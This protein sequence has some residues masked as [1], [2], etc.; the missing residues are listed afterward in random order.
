MPKAVTA[1]K[2]GRSKAGV[3]KAQLVREAF[4][5]LGIDASAKDV[6]AACD[7]HGVKIAPA[8]ISNI[9]TKLKEGR[10]GR[11][12]VKTTVVGGVTAKELI[13]VRIMAEKVGGIARAKELL[14]ILHRLR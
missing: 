1:A 14:D 2:R 9:R 5:K 4:E 11:K 6:Q 7:A 3:N 13:Q 8:Q 10:S 12:V